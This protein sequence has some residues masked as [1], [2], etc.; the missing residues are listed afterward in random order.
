ML[1]RT[2]ALFIFDAGLLVVVCTLEAVSL[3]GLPVHEWMALTFGAGLLAHILLQWTW[4]AS[5]TRRL[6][7][8]GAGRTRINYLINLGLFI[9]MVATIVS[10]I[11]I[12]EVALPVIGRPNVGGAWRDVH[13]FG[14]NL[15]VLFVGLHVG[16]NL[17][18]IAPVLRQWRE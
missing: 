3:T 8:A 18:W 11:M 1:N 17:D 10:G 2:K 5:R 7:A 6:L 14:T 13:G 16:L 12:S 9:S 4:I 15:V